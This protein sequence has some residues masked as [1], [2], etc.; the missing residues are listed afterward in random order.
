MKKILILLI[1]C[2]AFSCSDDDKVPVPKA[3]MLE[4][5]TSSDGSLTTIK[6]DS[7]RRVQNIS[8]SY[9]E[10]FDFAYNGDKI[11]ILD[12]SDSEFGDKVCGFTYDTNGKINKI[13]VNTEQK[14]VTY[15]AAEQSYFL[16][17][18]G[19]SFK[20]KLFVD[21]DEQITKM[22]SYDGNTVMS[23][24]T[25][26]YDSGTGAL[27][28]TNR[29]GIY[30][31][32]AL[33]D[34]VA[35]ATYLSGKVVKSDQYLEMGLTRTYTYQNLFDAENYVIKS[36]GEPFFNGEEYISEFHYIQL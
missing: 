3:K 12:Y 33:P 32:L 15:N 6:Y 30:M 9:G 36:I 20:Y 4:K 13:T 34:H 21:A 24:Y 26:I 8:L 35:L 11:S 29:I 28:N 17:T 7:S 16:T 5:I 31:A 25:V 23:E 14:N 18:V 19:S 27:A 22:I 1:A 2:A 10:V